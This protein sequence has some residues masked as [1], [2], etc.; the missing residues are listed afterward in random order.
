[1][2][3]EESTRQSESNRRRWAAIDLGGEAFRTGGNPAEEYPV[4]SMERAVDLYEQA[5]A[6]W[7]EEGDRAY[8]ARCCQYAI[9]AVKL[10]IAAK[11]ADEAIRAATGTGR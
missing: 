9:D 3:S 11:R 4:E 1:M 7:L 2:P 8:E 10:A 5:K 6:L